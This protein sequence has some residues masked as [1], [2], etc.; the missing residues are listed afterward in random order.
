[1]T[2]AREQSPIMVQ[3]PRPLGT[4]PRCD[5]PLMQPHSWKELGGEGLLLEL[6]CPECSLWM[7]GRFDWRLVARYDEEL[8]RGRGQIEHQY[9]SLVRH[10][11][12]EMADRL[13]K[14]L[15]LDLIGADDFAP[16]ARG[17]CLKS[18]RDPIRWRQ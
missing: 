4:C 5:S 16:A 1:M 11:M 14:A 18:P 3:S 8:S 7:V 9:L 13:A 15:D 6:R 17:E 12:E 10:N 2:R